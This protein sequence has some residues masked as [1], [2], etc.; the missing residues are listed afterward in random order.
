MPNISVQQITTTDMH[1]DRSRGTKRIFPDNQPSS[2]LHI[3]D[4]SISLEA[5]LSLALPLHGRALL[6]NALH[7]DDAARELVA[8]TSASKEKVMG[9]QEIT[10]QGPMPRWA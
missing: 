1:M 9:S 5:A 2:G 3:K 7:E 4:N 6:G 10:M 8:S